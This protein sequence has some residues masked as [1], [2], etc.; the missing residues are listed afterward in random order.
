MTQEAWLVLLTGV[1]GQ[2]CCDASG[3]LWTWMRLPRSN[4]ALLGAAVCPYCR[5]VGSV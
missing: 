3:E 2:T 4:S 5:I 1:H